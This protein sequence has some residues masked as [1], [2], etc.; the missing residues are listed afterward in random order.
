MYY[1]DF[2][3]DSAL[4]KQF[5]DKFGGS[6]FGKVPGSF[7]CYQDDSGAYYAPDTKIQTILF[8]ERSIQLNKNLFLEENKV[9]TST[10]AL[11]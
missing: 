3:E 2:D 5:L 1:D 10:N 7:V 8:M 4:V 6:F 11:S 9:K